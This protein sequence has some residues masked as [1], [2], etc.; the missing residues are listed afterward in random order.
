MRILTA[1]PGAVGLFLAARLSS[2]AEV[3][4]LHHDRAAAAELTERGFEVRAAAGPPRRFRLPCVVDPPESADLLLV[5]VKTGALP[6]LL[7][8]LAG[9]RAGAALSVQNGLGNC[10][11]LAARFGADR[12][13]GGV[14]TYGLHRTERRAVTAAGEGELAVGPWGGGRKAAEIVSLM[15]RAGLNARP[16]PDI[17]RELWLKAGVN[18][19]INP[20]AAIHGVP[21]GA[22][23]EMEETPGVWRRVAAE[24]AR[25]AALEGVR[26]EA[27]EVLERAERVAR[28]TAANRCSMLQD[29]EAGRPTEADAILG[30]IAGLLAAAGESGTEC[31]SLLEKIREL[32][33]DA[34]QRRREG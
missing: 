18:A 34:R 28:A 33:R 12:V 22:L 10:E 19:C 20:L 30:R 2:V 29:I 1:G 13:Y 23:L 25:A 8:S 7:E 21:N 27:E 3:V 15:R 5:T 26:L 11:R 24:T 9:L 17:R 4:L 16:S 14:F 6:A 32:E 31:G